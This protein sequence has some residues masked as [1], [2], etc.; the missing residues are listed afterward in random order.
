[1]LNIL[2]PL[3]QIDVTLRMLGAQRKILHSYVAFDDESAGMQL[4]VF[5]VVLEAVEVVCGYSR[6]SMRSR[7]SGTITDTRLS[8]NSLLIASNVWRMRTN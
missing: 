4:H 5:V 8:L 1:L 2:K 6:L 7:S 3:K